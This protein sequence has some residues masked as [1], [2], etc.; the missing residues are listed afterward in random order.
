MTP[1]TSYSDR[2]SVCNLYVC[3]HFDNDNT[4]NIGWFSV[5]GKL[6]VGLLTAVMYSNYW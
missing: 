1:T 5:K 4:D 2:Q 3:G 6:R